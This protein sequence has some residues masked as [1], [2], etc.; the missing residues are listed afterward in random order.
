MNIDIDSITGVPTFDYLNRMVFNPTLLLVLLIIMILYFFLFSSL[1]T[2]EVHKVTSKKDVNYLSIGVVSIFIVLMLLNGFNYF[3]NINIITSIKNFFTLE[4]EIDFKVYGEVQGDK[5]IPEIRYVEQV[6]HIPGNK[7]TYDDAK[8]LCKAYGNRLASYKDIKKAYDKGADWCSYGWS[9]D[10]L[11]LFPTQYAKWSK[12][13]DIDGHKHDC[14][15]P[16]I[17]GGYIKNPNVRFGV[18]CYGYKPKINAIESQLMANTPLY[19]QSQ[20]ELDFN[21]KVR[22][23]KNKI[24]DIIISPFN[25][26]NWSVV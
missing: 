18:N 3:L 19:P 22:H 12:L 20:K 9:A 4:P 15:R 23:W 26:K 2:S 6:Y 17:N 24:N 11:A 16:G 14:G 1:G 8:S 21:T 7:Y 13:Q 25:N 5:D 10:Q